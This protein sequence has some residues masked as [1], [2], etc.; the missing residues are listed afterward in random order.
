M[1]LEKQFNVYKGLPRNVYILFISTVINK[2]GG[3]ITPLM[4]LILTVKI[5][6]IESDVGLVSTLAML[7]Q[8]PF[9]L[10]GGSLVDRFGAKRMIVVMNTLGAMLYFIC[11]MI[12]PDWKLALVMI[13][14]AN[15]YAMAS[16]APNAL[17]PSVTS[18]D[19]V[20]NAYSLMYLGMNLGLAIGPLISGLL[21]TN[22]LKLLFI[23][24]GVTTLIS[25]AMVIIL[26]DEK[27]KIEGPSRV[28]N[29]TRV[30]EPMLQEPVLEEPIIENPMLEEHSIDPETTSIIGYLKKKPRL[31]A[32]TFILMLFN[33]CYIQW[34]FLLPLQSLD[35][36]GE[37]G[38]RHFSLLL[39]INAVTV[40]LL[41]P[42]LTSMTQSIASLKTIFY[43]GLFYAGSFFIFAV[44]HSL[45]L[46]VFGIIILTIG[47]ILI[48][49]NVNHYITTSVSPR[50]LGR[51]N[52]IL[53][54]FS[55]V[56][57]AIGPVVMGNILV[58]A[59]YQISWLITMGITTCAAVM[60]WM[61]YRKEKKS[62]IV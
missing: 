2:I 34:N 35:I 11:A 30:E 5:G 29:E 56:G 44:S 14:A 25:V 24:D 61:L 52:S 26:F 49:I 32:V 6:L 15:F 50:F 53:F 40:V 8:A 43:G 57:Y 42:V 12:E 9:I 54:I 27:F 46:F 13:M 7:S 1:V 58:I 37:A 59:N 51:A 16:P 3:F 62:D 36:F 23:I 60:M 17:I 18:K 47:E 4:T 45:L 55:G 19:K 33:F 28:T 22:H 20:K 41:S 10:V 48:A 38:A 39:S 21:F 31:L